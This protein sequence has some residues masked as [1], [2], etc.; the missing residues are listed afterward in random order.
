MG[1]YDKTRCLKDNE[2]YGSYWNGGA[3]D[4]MKANS[5][6]IK[7]TIF[8]IDESNAGYKARVADDKV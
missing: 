6:C 8:A 5:C 2:A 4:N 7:S 1:G 3:N